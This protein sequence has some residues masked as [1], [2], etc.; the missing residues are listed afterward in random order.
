MNK[1]V[2]TIL[3]FLTACFLFFSASAARNIESY[4]EVS[5]RTGPGTNYAKICS[6]P[7]GRTVRALEYEENGSSWYFV[8]FYLNGELT[9]GYIKKQRQ[10]RP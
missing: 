4:G 8:E 7:K 6:L 2:R 10:D 3:L 5:I 9:R 1:T